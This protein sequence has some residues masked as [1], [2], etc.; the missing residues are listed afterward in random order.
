MQH[1]CGRQAFFQLGFGCKGLLSCSAKP[2]KASIETLIRVASE[3]C[4]SCPS[5]LMS[6]DRQLSTAYVPDLFAANVLPFVEPLTGR[7]KCW[8]CCAEPGTIRRRQLQREH[9]LPQQCGAARLFRTAADGRFQP[10]CQL[11]QPP[12]R[13]VSRWHHGS[14][15]DT[16]VLRPGHPDG[17]VLLFSQHAVVYGL[18][19]WLG[20]DCRLSKLVPATGKN[21]SFIELKAN[22]ADEDPKVCSVCKVLFWPVANRSS[23]NEAVKRFAYF[24]IPYL[25]QK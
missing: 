13:G 1:I 24:G 12:G 4:F 25:F 20:R 7:L 22:L 21:L 9:R 19:C 8:A 14:L 2:L 16:G 23:G 3:Q 18:T 17:S 5:L 6:A 10:A 15:A 11:S